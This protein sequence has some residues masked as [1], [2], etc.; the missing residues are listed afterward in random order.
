MIGEKR[1]F[2]D[3]GG[4]PALS[5]VIVSPAGF[6]GVLPILFDIADQT[7]AERIE[8]LV[9]TPD[10]KSFEPVGRCFRNLHS[11]HA[12]HAGRFS[13]RGQAAGHAILNARA[14]VVA[15]T[16]NH[17]FPLPDWAEVLLRAHQGPWTGVAPSVEIFNPQTAW[18]RIASFLDYGDWITIT[19]STESTS[20]PWHNSSYKRD[21][22][23]ALHD[24]L[25]T[26]LEPENLLQERL[27]AQGH[28]FFIEA[29]A[30]TRHVGNSTVRTAI[31][32]A[33][34][35]G[36]LFALVRRKNWSMPRRLLYAAAWPLFPII[37]LVK[38]APRIRS[39]NKH[40][41]VAP[42]LP[43]IFFLLIATSLG[44]CLGY[45]GGMGRSEH[46][47]LRH[48]LDLAYRVNER[49]HAEIL[50]RVEARRRQEVD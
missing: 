37:R 7:M 40:F 44:E 14:P 19:E 36:R 24:E 38:L 48:E 26:L 43:G 4:D 8:L 3:R 21:P 47:L 16:E 11:F 5:V 46:F 41:A 25:F 6:E 23:I 49:E 28:R 34:A 33:L 32:A 10:L 30:R 12:I 2:H 9:S 18:S 31:L 39:Y 13:T 17:A 27:R 1:T 15:L 45:L 20:M 35:L 42:L 29:R 22:L 50:S